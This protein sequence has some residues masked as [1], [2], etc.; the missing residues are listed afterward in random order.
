MKTPAPERAAGRK[1][2]AAEGKALPDGSEPIPN[3]AYLKKAIRSVG[4]LDPAKRPAL[5][6]LIV[7][8]AKELNALNAPGVKGTW[9]FQGSGQNPAVTLS[10]GSSVA[11][12]A[13]NFTG[14]PYAWRAIDLVG[15]KGFIHG[16]IKV[17]VP[18]ADH[19]ISEAKKAE[20]EGR[21]GDAINHL[22]AAIGKT[23][24]KSA[25]FHLTELRSE[26][27]ARRMG[28][29]Y[30]P[31]ARPK[32]LHAM[33]NDDGEAIN[34]A[35]TLPRRM[36]VVRG[37]ADVQ[38]SRTGPGVIS[39][40]HKSTGMKL[41]TIT[42]KGAGYG[43]AHSDGTAT[44]ASG[45]QQGALAGLIRYHNQMA[46]AKNAKTRDAAQ[47]AGAGSASVKGYA[48][49]QPALDFASA[50][51]V[52][53]SDGPRVTSMG[54]GKA[55]PA[56]TK[57]GLSPECAKVYAKLRK[58]GLDHGAAMSLARRAAAMHAKAAA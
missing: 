42:P 23:A 3:L 18:E 38:M 29:A 8:R 44:P 15:P 56:A 2:L 57:L 36:P 10:T 14:R 28:K 13:L 32:S 6:A 21:H 37:A 51:S 16:W 33:A 31:K 53:S 30:K 40:M 19:H 17:G 27:A 12:Y 25:A 5:K 20:S 9:A 46:A 48:G 49:D 50:P 11:S 22:T 7:R 35:S 26:M 24:D 39:V 58:K 52:T 34:L 4:R 43:A 47:S 1:K 55:S 54:G 45:S 41:G